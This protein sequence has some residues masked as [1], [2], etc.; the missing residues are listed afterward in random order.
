MSCRVGNAFL[1]GGREAEFSEHSAA[2]SDCAGLSRRMDDLGSLMRSLAAPPLPAGLRAGLLD[3]PSRTVSCE[4][5]DALLALA[6][7]T[8]IAPGDEARWSNHLTRCAACSEAAQTLFA[9]RGLAAPVPAPWLATRLRAGKPATTR[10]R[11]RKARGGLL[12]FLWSPKGA[13]ALAY[14]A[15]VVVMLSGFDPAGLARKAGMARLEDATGAAVAAARTGA[16]ERIGTLEE[17]ALRSLTVL[18]GRVLGY[19]RATLVNAL[20]LVMRTETTDAKRPPDRPKNGG[21]RGVLESPDGVSLAGKPVP[22]APQIKGW[23]A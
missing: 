16:V 13:V 10:T 17:K 21:G 7:E 19:G 6:L 12:A 15:A 22:A 4:G 23:R 20:A 5:S 8:E 11:T 2:C 9:A 1:D 3:I 14:A 18:K